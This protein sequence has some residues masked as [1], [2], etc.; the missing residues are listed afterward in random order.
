MAININ[1]AWDAQQFYKE[2]EEARKHINSAWDA[3]QYYQ[4]YGGNGHAGN[5]GSKEWAV[6]QYGNAYV[7]NPAK[8]CWSLTAL[9]P[10]NT[11]SFKSSK[12]SS[13]KGISFKGGSSGAI[14]QAGATNSSKDASTSSKT[15]AEKEYIDIEFNTLTGDIELIPTKNNLKIKVN[16]TVNLK[17][18]G[19]YLSGLYFV[20][21]IKHRI[22]KDGGYSMTMTLFKNGFGESLKSSAVLDSGA[23]SPANDGRADVVDTTENVVTSKI[24]VGDKVKIV[25]DNATYANA[26]DGVKVPNWV[27]QQVLTVDAISSDGNRARVNP[28]WSW[29]Y[30][31]YLKLV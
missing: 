5:W 13:G 9:P 26:Y 25:G 27:K 7:Y 29:T 18:V 1:S 10:F 20:S 28:I 4:T 16:N 11:T 22:D 2:K 17:G 14:S 19:K 24:K 6:Q 30:V 23:T 3:Q 31:K 15:A 12:I 21:E 8:H